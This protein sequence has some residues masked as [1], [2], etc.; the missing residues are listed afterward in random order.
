MPYERESTVWLSVGRMANEIDAHLA[1]V[2]SPE[3]PIGA[4]Q[5]EPGPA[6]L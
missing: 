3:V 2:P 1:A 4:P 6:A 5:G